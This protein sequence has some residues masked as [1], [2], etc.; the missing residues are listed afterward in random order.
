MVRVKA[1]DADPG[2]MKEGLKEAI[3][4]LGRPDAD[5]AIG[6]EKDAGFCI[7]TPKE[8]VV[9]LPATMEAH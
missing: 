5:N 1:F 6:L 9:G 7:C 8:K 4:P 2:G 3:A